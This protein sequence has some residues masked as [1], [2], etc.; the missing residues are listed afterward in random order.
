MTSYTGKIKPYIFEPKTNS[1]KDFSQNASFRKPFL[2]SSLSLTH[3][4]SNSE[5]QLLKNKTICIANQQWYVR[6][7]ILSLKQIEIQAFKNQIKIKQNLF[8]DEIN[9]FIS[10]EI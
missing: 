2:F 8:F 3:T 7:H 1:E 10:E 5:H 9:L 4:Y 6:K